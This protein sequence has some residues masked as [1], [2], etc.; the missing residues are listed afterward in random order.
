MFTL[1]KSLYPFYNKSDKTFTLPN[2]AVGRVKLK[3]KPKG[4]K[5]KSEPS[6]IIPVFSAFFSHASFLKTDSWKLIAYPVKDDKPMHVFV[7][8]A[9]LYVIGRSVLNFYS[10]P[11]L[12]SDIALAVLSSPPPTHTSDSFSPRKPPSIEQLQLSHWN[13]VGQRYQEFYTVLKNYSKTIEEKAQTSKQTQ[14][15]LH[16]KLQSLTIQDIMPPSPPTCT[17]AMATPNPLTTAEDLDEPT[18]LKST[19][20]QPI[21]APEHPPCP[22][23]RTHPSTDNKESNK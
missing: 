5:L 6:T 9:T 13:G 8:P 22:P 18:T 15:D 10:D 4:T 2:V 7:D 3:S 1:P 23:S 11:S 14:D 19:K 16:E 17:A 21:A 20:S 12:G